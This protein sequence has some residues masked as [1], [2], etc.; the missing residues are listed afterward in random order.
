MSTKPA[1]V[2]MPAPADQLFAPPDADA[3]HEEWGANCGPAALAAVLGLTLAQIRPH[4][5]DFEQRR[6]MNPT[7]LRAAL[8]S[9]GV[10]YV[11]DSGA[12]PRRP[13]K[14][15]LFIQWGGPWLKPGVPVGVAYRHTHSI[16]VNGD[17]VYDVNAEEGWIS[18][19][20]WE[21]PTLGLAAWLM[22]HNKRC[23]GTWR[24]RTSI[25]L[26]EATGGA[27]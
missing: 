8:D 3:A 13:K 11:V 14:G 17:L 19:R 15:L 25:A 24:V 12:S 10:R 1:Q 23:D 18:R 2:L 7:H 26:I 5:G 21:H 27:L 9:V 20:E 6:Y 22:E 16:A 4:L